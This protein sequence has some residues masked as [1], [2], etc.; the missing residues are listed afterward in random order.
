MQIASEWHNRFWLCKA[1]FDAEY[2]KVSPGQLLYWY[3]LS[4]SVEKGHAS[5]EL[6]G[7]AAEWTRAWTRDDREF[8]DVKVFPLFLSS[9]LAFV[10]TAAPAVARRIWWQTPWA[11]KD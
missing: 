10:Q 4:R 1:S 9:L 6:M 2:R 8:V 11:A 7:V 5:Y 3:T